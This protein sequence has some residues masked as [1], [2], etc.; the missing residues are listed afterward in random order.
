M[1]LAL[2]I[3]DAIRHPAWEH[4]RTNPQRYI[5]VQSL[6]T[7]FRLYMNRTERSVPMDIC[8]SAGCSDKDDEI[9]AP[10]TERYVF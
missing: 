7:G 8:R 1:T 6:H 3:Q 2:T 5:N 10:W 4:L 9:R